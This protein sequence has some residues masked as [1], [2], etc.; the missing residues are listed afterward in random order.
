MNIPVHYIGTS[1]DDGNYTLLWVVSD[2][3]IQ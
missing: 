1:E 3:L 2:K